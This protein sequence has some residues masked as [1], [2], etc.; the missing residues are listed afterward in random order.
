MCLIYLKRIT[1]REKKVFFLYT[2]LVAIL[3]VVGFS[4]LYIY[5]SQFHYYLV[6]RVYNIIEYSI[7][8][9][10]FYL[11]ITNKV[12]KQILLFSLIP[13]FILCIYDF[14]VAKEAALPFLPLI[15]EY[16]ILLVFIIYFFFEVM[17]N[18]VIEPIYNKAIFWISVAFIINFSGNFF[19]FLYSKSSYD[20]ESF[21]VQYTVIYTTVT[22]I[23]NLLLCIAIYIKERETKTPTNE[24]V[25]L[26]LDS[27]FTSKNHN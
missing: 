17:Q 11:H 27:Y 14:I 26:D 6:V 19:L 12:V 3:V 7:L 25:S 20:N 1:T 9:Y 22:V 18:V 8:A 16:F 10:L 2:L 24:L 21:K 23:K 15:V 4:L 13:Y 5:K